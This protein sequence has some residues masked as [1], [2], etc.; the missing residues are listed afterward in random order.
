[1]LLLNMMQRF[2]MVTSNVCFVVLE[3]LFQQLLSISVSQ[4]SIFYMCI[5]ITTCP[6]LIF[7]FIIHEKVKNDILMRISEKTF[8]SFLATNQPSIYVYVCFCFRFWNL[9]ISFYTDLFCIGP[10]IFNDYSFIR[11]NTSSCTEIILATLG[12]WYSPADFRI[13]L[14]VIILQ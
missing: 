9:F 14:S 3:V 6:V 12:F 2:V 4:G 5:I 7:M 11:P 1:M 8:Y 10:P 13:I